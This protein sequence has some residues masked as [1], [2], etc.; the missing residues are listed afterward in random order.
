MSKSIRARAT[1]RTGYHQGFG[2]WGGRAN[3]GGVGRPLATIAG[4]N[5]TAPTFMFGG[6]SGKPMKRL[7]R[8]NALTQWHLVKG[9]V[10]TKEKCY[11]TC[12]HFA[13]HYQH[14]DA[15]TAGGVDTMANKTPFN[16]INV[17]NWVTK[18]P[19]EKNC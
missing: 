5:R 7:K 16:R 17:D 10:K 11:D 13:L 8:T 9:V 15:E 6:L 19:T 1:A 4:R 3:C 2:P 12:K 18:H 14:P